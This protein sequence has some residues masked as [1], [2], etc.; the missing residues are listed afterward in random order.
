MKN[1]YLVGLSVFLLVGCASPV[2]FTGDSEVSK[3][4]ILKFSEH[5]ESVVE[6][7]QS[8]HFIDHVELNYKQEQLVEML[9]NDSTRFVNEFFCGNSTEGQFICPDFDKIVSIDL[10]TINQE[11]SGIYKLTYKIVNTMGIIINAEVFLNTKL[12]KYTMYSA[13]G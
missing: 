2:V 4:N 6:L 12:E 10:T 3:K 9:Q 13:V 8:A 1:I 11:S 5:I 7:H